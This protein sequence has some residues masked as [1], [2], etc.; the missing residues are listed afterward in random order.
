M[1]TNGCDGDGSIG[2][3]G[4]TGKI[5]KWDAFNGTLLPTHYSTGWAS[6]LPYDILLID[7]PVAGPP[8]DLM[9]TPHGQEGSIALSAIHGC[10][11]DSIGVLT[12]H[13]A[14]I[15]AVAYRSRYQQ[16]ISAATDGLL[17]I[18]TPKLHLNTGQDDDE[19]EE[20]EVI[21]WQ[22]KKKAKTSQHGQSDD[23]RNGNRIHYEASNQSLQSSSS[24]TTAVYNNNNDDNNTEFLPPIIRSYIEDT[25]RQN[26]VA[27]FAVSSNK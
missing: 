26:I 17:N 14:R 21:P 8:A 27:T 11:N 18:W 24:S 2:D 15:T 1:I 22:R 16:L 3:V 25:Q 23:S 12:A 6:T 7:D 9:V 20:E 5:R 19:D 4:Y 10:Q 13:F